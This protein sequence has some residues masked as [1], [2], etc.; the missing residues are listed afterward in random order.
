M[1]IQIPRFLSWVVAILIPGIIIM[2]ALRL[3]L[4]PVFLDFEYRIPGFPEDPFGFSQEERLKYSRIIWKYVMSDAEISFLGDL[5]FPEGQQAPETSCQF[6]DDCTRLYND[7]ELSHMIDV[8]NVVQTALR[9]WYVALIVLALLG[10]W[11]CRS[12]WM[13]DYLVGLVRGGWITVFLVVG[14]LSI[15]VIAFGFIFVQFHNIFFEK[16]T[17][18]FFTSDTLIR[19]FPTEFF[20]D[21]FLI[22]GILSAGMGILLALGLRR[23][24]HR[25]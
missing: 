15:V 24:I 23:R 9:V 7:R 3:L 11:A 13:N 25:D 22:V 16:G 6:M 14:I 2:T 10:I 12:Q 17:W 8:Q 21:M 18:M 4:F 19:L 5:H 20:R 1:K